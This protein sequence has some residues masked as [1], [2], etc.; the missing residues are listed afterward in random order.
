MAVKIVRTILKQNT[1]V[2]S[3]EKVDMLFDFIQPL[4]QDA[5]DGSE[6]S[7]DEEVSR[8]SISQPYY[9]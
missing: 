2:G 5:E 8:S 3:L 1:A 6:E 9:P 7:D 4:I